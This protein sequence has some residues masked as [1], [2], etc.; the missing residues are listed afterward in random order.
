VARA[1]SLSPDD[2]EYALNAFPLFSRKHP[3]FFAYLHQC[4]EELSQPEGVDG[5]PVRTNG[6]YTAPADSDAIGELLIF[7]CTCLD[8]RRGGAVEDSPGRKRGAA[9]DATSEEA[10]S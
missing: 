3:D 7:G 2:L 9:T 10:G 5:L 6:W 4:L 8:A 1:S